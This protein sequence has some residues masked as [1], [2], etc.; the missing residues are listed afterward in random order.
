V[1]L[2]PPA[3]IVIRPAEPF[4]LGALQEIEVAAGEQFRALGMA[5]IADD[6]PPS[7]PDLAVF[8]GDGRALVAV[9]GSGRI[10]GYLLLETLDGDAHVGQVSVHPDLARRGIGRAL[11][12]AAAD[13]GRSQGLG[14][15]TLTTFAEVPWN[16]PYYR[17]LGFSELP[18]SGLGPELARVRDSEAA[19]G[20]ARWPRVVLSRP[21]G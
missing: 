1:S 19:A 9:E 4:E 14:N 6:Q 12:A 3:G 10:A 8:Q 5:D 15:L 20:L 21:L 11:L 7:L 2:P 16:A 13:W 17:R 18:D